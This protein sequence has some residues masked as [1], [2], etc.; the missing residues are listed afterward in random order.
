MPSFSGDYYRRLRLPRTASKREIKLAFRRLA[1]LH[2]PDLH[3]HQPN[4]VAKFHELREAY[5][6]LSDRVQRQRYDRQQAGSTFAGS[7]SA[8]SDSAKPA[9]SEDLYVRGIRYALDGRYQAALANYTR[10]IALD[11]QF[12]EAYLRRAEVLYLLKDDREV[13]SN[14]QQAIHLNSTEA[15]TYYFQGLARYRLGYVESAIAAFT[16]AIACDPEDAR[17]YHHRG[18]SHRDLKEIDSAAKDLRVSA[19]LYKAQGNQVMCEQVK[20]TLRPMGTAGLSWHRKLWAQTSRPVTQLLP[21]RRRTTLSSSRHST[22]F[23]NASPSV[24]SSSAIPPLETSRKKR[25]DRIRTRQSTFR[26][27]QKSSQ[28]SSQ[29]WTPG[30][31]SRPS[32][33]EP[34]KKNIGRGFVT[35]LKL[36]SNPAGELLPVYHQLM[37]NRQVS[38]VGY[39]LAVLANLLFVLGMT[40]YLD[41]S[42]WTQASQFWAVGGI[43]FVAMMFLVSSVRVALRVRGLWA[44]DV[45]ILATAVVPLGLFAAM[46]AG[47]DLVVQQLSVAYQSQVL[48]GWV[49]VSGLWAVSHSVMTLRSGFSR[50][51]AF[52]DKTASWFAPVVLGAGLGLGYV[53]WLLSSPVV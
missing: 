26:V 21:I 44:A 37:S 42:S 11:P 41:A 15:Q 19:K 28:S 10:A 45:F 49:L 12:S 50:I 33:Y 43:T 46:G 6:V 27:A 30:V 32:A 14:C 7:Q 23:Y 17:Y 40:Q 22:H 4:A 35:T 29:S 16:N 48:L 5:E 47:A 39:G 3:P 1:R 2:H 9:T 36:L 18:L 38:L 8:A 31:S 34:P 25:A 52:S 13:L 53:V 51:Q 20:D 24:S